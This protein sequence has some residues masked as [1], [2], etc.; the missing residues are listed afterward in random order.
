MANET[1]GFALLSTK[2]ANPCHYLYI[3]LKDHLMC[4]S[5]KKEELELYFPMKFLDTVENK[6]GDISKLRMK[7]LINITLAH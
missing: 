4:Y 1:H 6:F 3:P 5:T 7:I 2:Q